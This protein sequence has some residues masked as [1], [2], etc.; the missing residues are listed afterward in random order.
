[1]VNTLQILMIKLYRKTKFLMNEMAKWIEQRSSGIKAEEAIIEQSP[2]RSEDDV[3]AEEFCKTLTDLAKEVYG[4]TDPFDISQRVLRATCNF[5]EADWC[6]MFDTDMMLDLWMPFWW[7]NRSTGGMTETQL[8]QGSVMGSFERFRQMIENN[9]SVYQE[10]ITNIRDTH[11]EEYALFVSQNVKSFMAVPYSRRER[12]IIFLRNPKKFGGRQEMLRIASNILIQEINE[13]KHIDRMKVN[14]ASA[15]MRRD[16]DIIINLFGGIEVM[17]EQGKMVEAEM[18]SAVCSKLFVFLM[19]NKNRSI[20]A[21]TLCDTI[22]AGKEY[23]NPISNLRS[24]LYRLRNM[25]DLLFEGDLIVTSK[26]GYRINPDI[27]IHT[28]FE[29]FEKLCTSITPSMPKEIKISILKE[30][31]EIYDGKLFP[32]GDGELWLISYVMHYRMMY[33]DAVQKLMKL[34]NVAGDY[35]TMQNYAMMAVQVEPDNLK[36]IYWLVIALRENGAVDMMKKHLDSARSRLL[37][38]E[39]RELERMLGIVA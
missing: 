11:P 23:E 7:F 19:L 35:Q 14:A 25:F 27:R 13:Q 9:T 28:D 33:L 31:V 32:S 36:F 34:L 6:G 20:P 17:T 12:G 10:D 26:T 3:Y 22:W 29:H 24:T 2:V 16:A 39:Y 18:N 37:E 15:D 4:N 1:M 38:E 8:H 30:A 21:S 5:Y